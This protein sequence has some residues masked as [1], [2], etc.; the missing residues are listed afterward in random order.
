MAEPTADEELAASV[1]PNFQYGLQPTPKRA[2]AP[3]HRPRKQF[4]REQQWRNQIEKLLDEQPDPPKELAYLGLPG[5]DLLDIRYFH[6]EICQPRNLELRFLGFNTSQH[7][8]GAGIDLNTSLAEVHD[9]ESVHEASEVLRDD[10]RAIADD[11]SQAW[12]RTKRMGPFDV[13]NLDLCDGFAKE[14]ETSE[15]DTHYNALQH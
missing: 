8:S 10:F 5:S 2:F 3:W 1:V 12:S 11:L 13:I 7:T 4:V 6:G 9:L 14:P 15:Q